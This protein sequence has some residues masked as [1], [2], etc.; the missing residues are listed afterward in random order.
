MNRSK[1][2]L[3]ACQQWR[4]LFQIVHH[5]VNDY[6]ADIQGSADVQ[7]KPHCSTSGC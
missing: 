4:V 5:F 6:N 1:D 7:V 3:F 2:P